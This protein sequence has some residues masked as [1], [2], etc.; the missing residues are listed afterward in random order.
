[1]S[2]DAV[3]TDTEPHYGERGDPM[4]EVRNL[5]TYYDQGGLFGGT[6]VKAVD[7]VSFDIQQGE[8]LG[9]VGESEIGRAHV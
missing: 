1:M 3:S 2:Q 7:G 8:T 9:L 6:P 4:V 5:K